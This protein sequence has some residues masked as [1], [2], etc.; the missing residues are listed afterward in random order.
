MFSAVRNTQRVY[1]SR[2][3][4]ALQRV[5]VSFVR[6]HVIRD[7]PLQGLPMGSHR[8]PLQV[9]MSVRRMHRHSTPRDALGCTRG[10]IVSQVT[11]A[12]GNSFMHGR[13]HCCWLC[14][15]VNGIPASDG[16]SSSPLLLRATI[17]GIHLSS[18][19]KC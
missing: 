13:S 10:T 7:R 17:H 16:I 19:T 15:H 1:L 4:V 5:H 12:P 9:C 14:I 3:T 8:G 18:K 11:V 2:G 6:V